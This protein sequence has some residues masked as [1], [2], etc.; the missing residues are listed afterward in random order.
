M[1]SAYKKNPKWVKRV[2]EFF[3]QSDFNKHNYLSIEDFDMWIDNIEKE[4][5]KADP[6][7]LKKLREVSHEY[8]ESTVGLKPGIQITKDQFADKM[9]EFAAADGSKTL[10]LKYLDALH[11]VGDTTGDGCLTLDEYTTLLKA[12]NFGADL[13]KT[14][15]ETVNKNHDGKVSLQD[16]NDYAAN[17]W[18]TLD[19]SESAG[20]FGAKFE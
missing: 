13:A 14:V 4:V 19:H 20:M 9:A 12:C 6:T 18:F 10:Q 7:L 3:V 17:F 8:W 2:E 15:F 11:G 16:L 5:V 1:A